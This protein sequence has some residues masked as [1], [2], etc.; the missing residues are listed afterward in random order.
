MVFRAKDQMRSPRDGC[1][2][3]RD[4]LSREMVGNQE[5]GMAGAR[6]REETGRAWSP[7]VR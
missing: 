3:R 4:K 6:R 2:W 5:A 7:E 1:G